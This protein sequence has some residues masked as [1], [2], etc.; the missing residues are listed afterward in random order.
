MFRENKTNDNAQR[1][2]ERKRDRGREGGERKSYL[3][4]LSIARLCSVKVRWR[5]CDDCGVR[6]RLVGMM[7][8][9]Y[10]RI[11]SRKNH[12]SAPFSN[13]NSTCSFAVRNGY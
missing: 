11:A 4:K 3:T 7:L 6:L 5:E 10:N 8:T 12:F 1:E 9:G 2:R 13:P